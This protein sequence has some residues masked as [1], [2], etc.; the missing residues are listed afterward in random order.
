MNFMSPAHWW[1]LYGGDTLEL[2]KVAGNVLSCVVSASAYERCWSIFDF[3]YNK[4]GNRLT[5]ERAD[6][7]VFVYSNLQQVNRMLNMTVEEY[8]RDYPQ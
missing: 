3:I 7:L 5:T 1:T 4:R 8:F 2:A 6:D